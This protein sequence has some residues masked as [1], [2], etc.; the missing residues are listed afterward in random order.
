MGKKIKIEAELEVFESVSDLSPT[1]QNLMNKHEGNIS[2]KAMPST[3][4]HIVLTFPLKRNFR[5]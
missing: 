1:I 3:G 4:S 5:K 2:Y